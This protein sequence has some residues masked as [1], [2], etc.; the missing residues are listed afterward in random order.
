MLIRQP[1]M[2]TV[3]TRHVCE[4]HKKYP[5]QNYAGC[6]CSGSYGAVVKPMKDWTDAEKRHY[7]G[8]ID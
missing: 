1:P 7:F 4:F 8:I 3:T 6:T 2:K 5:G